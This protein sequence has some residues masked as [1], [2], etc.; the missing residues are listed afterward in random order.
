MKLVLDYKNRYVQKKHRFDSLDVNRLV[1]LLDD[2]VE[3]TNYFELLNEKTAEKE[4]IVYTSSQVEQYKQYIEDTLFFHRDNLLVPSYEVL[5]CHENKFVQELYNRKYQIETN[6]P[7]YLLGDKSEFEQLI[8]SGRLE[9]PFV[10]KGINGSSSLNVTICY[11]YDEGRSA[12]DKLY[13]PVVDA[14]NELA[15]KQHN[16][17]PGENS[18]HRQVVIQKYIELPNHDWRVHIM[19]NRY[20]G[21]KRTLIDDSK[22]ASG[23]GSINDYYCEIP[24]HVLE[25]AKSVFDKIESPFAILDVVDLGASCCLIEWSAIQLGIV[26]LLNGVRYYQKIDGNWQR[27]DQTPDIEFEFARAINQ[28]VETHRSQK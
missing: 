15:P 9:L 13:K 16:L 4:V 24:E 2:Q 3:V 22:Y 6:I 28:Y 19:G 20:W 7:A 25:Y 17:Y 14:Y 27:H 23:Q 18:T 10:V 8:S 21:H 11:S 12:I 5:R 26:S 1:E